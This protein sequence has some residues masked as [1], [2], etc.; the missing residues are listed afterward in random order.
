MTRLLAAVFAAALAGP[1][2]A[3]APPAGP[4]RATSLLTR[5]LVGIP[6]KEV[7]MTVL[8]IAPGGTSP[9]HRHN[10]N[11]FVYVLEG[12]MVMQVEGSPPVTLGP[13]QTFYET[14]TDIH[15][16]SRNPSATAPAKILVVFVKD[17]GAPA[18]VPAH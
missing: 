7:A 9:P 8:E 16:Q 14:P 17:V 1:A 4:V 13:G 3:Q 18:T 15:S 12:T 11:T 6:G 10:A 2:L 5:P